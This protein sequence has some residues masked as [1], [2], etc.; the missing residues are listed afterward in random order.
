MD[1]SLLQRFL[2]EIGGFHV[3]EIKSVEIHESAY[4]LYF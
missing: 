4:G 2:P 3:P 1:E